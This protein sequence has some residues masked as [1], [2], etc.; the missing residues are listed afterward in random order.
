MSVTGEKDDT[1]NQNHKQCF[2]HLCEKWYIQSKATAVCATCSGDGQ[3]HVVMYIC[4]LVI[5]QSWLVYCIKMK[6]FLC[7]FSRRF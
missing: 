7:S 1:S 4:R 6:V 5:I 2:F 3:C